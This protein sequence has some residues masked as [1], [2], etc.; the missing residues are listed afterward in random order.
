MKCNWSRTAGFCWREV[1]WGV[2]WDMRLE[3]IWGQVT[4]AL[5]YQGNKLEL[6]LEGKE[7]TIEH[8]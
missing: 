4:K 8:P 3:K 1:A 2:W 7:G 6:D 5:S